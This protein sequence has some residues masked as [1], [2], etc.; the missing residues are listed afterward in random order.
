MRTHFFVVLSVCLLT[1]VQP[2][3]SQQAS[4]E[5]RPVSNAERMANDRYSRSHD[6]DLLHERI[7]IG[8][9][10]W[11]G[12][13]FG[14]RV[15][16][17]L[18]AL[19]PAF[20]SVILDAGALL[21]ITDVYTGDRPAGR[22]V[23]SV[24]LGF[25]HVRDTLA[26]HLARP[27]AMGDTVRFTIAYQGRVKNGN[28]LTFLD[29]D[30]LPPRRPRQLWS[31][32]EDDN[33][34][35]W[36]PT[37][38]FPNDKATWELIAT[39]PKGFTAVSNGSLIADR[40]NRD[41]TRTMHW[42]QQRPSATYL[43]SLVVAPLVKIPDRWRAVPVDY[44]V[45]REDSA[46]A[47]PLF[48]VTPDM[49]EVY[50]RLTG[51]PYPWAKYAQTTVAD[52]FGGMENV[53]ATTLVDWLPDARAYADRPWYQHILIPHELAHQWFGDYVTTA[54]WAH[55][56]LNEGFAEFLPGQYWGAKGG[57]HAE[58]DYY[59]DEYQQF[60]GIDRR[61]RMPL[62]SLGS[63]NIY[64]KGALVLEMLKK[65]LGE[66]RFWAGVHRYLAD[67]AY[68]VAT[69]DDLRQA[70]LEA[71]GENLDWFWDQ[72]VY[73]AG[74]PEFRVS[75]TWDS[76][77]ATV[78]VTV[79]QHQRDTL[80]A[81]STGFRFET[82]EV[83]RMPVA[84]RVG[85]S[86]GS[87]TAR[88]MLERREQVI[89]IA[90]VHSAPTMVVFDDGNGILKQLAFDQPTA[91]L[92]TQLAQDP[93]LWNRSWVIAQLGERKNDS[94]ALAA[95]LRAA[96]SADYFLTRVQ[97]VGALA[98][99]TGAGAGAGVGAALLQ[100]LADTSAEVRA[101]AAE[102]LGGVPTPEV[103][104]AVRRAWDHDESDVVRGAALRTLAHLDPLEAR[105]L[106]RDA[107]LMPSYQ[108]VISNAAAFAAV[109]LKDSVLIDAV[110][111][112]ADRTSGG[113][114]ALAA[115]GTA[116]ASRAL[117]L[118]GA[119]AL[120]PRASARKLALQ[121]FRFAVPAEAARERLAALLAQAS[122]AAIREELQAALAR[123]RQ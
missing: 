121:A 119:Q 83:F 38:D 81:D 88:V 50:S 30:S 91:W 64:P 20:D 56:W 106:V 109:Q 122:D 39:V 28:G 41:G 58:D 60:L 116:G 62:A 86:T 96:T 112:V 117:D 99:F 53:S 22:N 24:R 76:T 68:G 43:V 26:V 3:L 49:I 102:A 108:D 32:G 73:R 61:R 10:D 95:L 120:S 33:N 2:A 111:A 71:T 25:D 104:A 23:G 80:P 114:F 17:T 115:F 100:A 103:L 89:H 98:E 29:A 97:A 48:R 52:F 4:L 13:S 94:E 85:T 79:Q 1:R 90:G 84:I 93:D 12:L 63:N 18:R 44:Y 110:A 72:W 78:T 66:Q 92:A 74:Y 107:L 35:D 70:F 113:A 5:G 40:A 123:L 77:I 75:A 36:F 14:G 47:R 27:V 57:R 87:V 82:P 16:V 67:H 42:S 118:L 15:T 7:E 31:Q 54:N 21:E 69:S 9:F 6:Y 101:S 34:H 59:L 8:R 51:V 37:Y 19:R 55:M 46:R 65:H 45:Y 11:D 105:A